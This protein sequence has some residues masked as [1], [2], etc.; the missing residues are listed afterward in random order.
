MTKVASN[1][2]QFELDR[3]PDAVAFSPDGR[4]LLST[5]TF[6]GTKPLKVMDTDG[7]HERVI[8]DSSASKVGIV[9]PAWSPDGQYIAFT[10][11][12]MGLRNPNNAAQLALIRADGSGLKVLTDGPNHSGFPSFSP[13]G[14]RLVYRVLGT[15]EGLRIL[16]LADGK[17]T[18][19]TDGHDN[20]P[21]WSP[22]GDRIVFTSYRT[23][24]FEIY[25]IRPDGKDLRQLTRDGGNDAHAAWSPDGRS[26]LFTTSRTGWKDEAA[27][28]PDA[29]SYGE[30][31][32]MRADG[33]H[34][35][36]LTD[37]QWE[38]AGMAWLPP[39]AP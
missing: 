24:N 7:T 21:V 13:D 23:G 30:L 12:R 28:Y 37:N 29:Q 1:D 34:V 14:Q 22:T 38:D 8:F 4:S 26:L 3:V 27:L 2:P 10:M 36:Q 25:T 9:S 18:H 35:R 31:A 6:L 33:T 11:G 17:I 15:E 5:S 39:A 32:I 19:L 16:N 20:F